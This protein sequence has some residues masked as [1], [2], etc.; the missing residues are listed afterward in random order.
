MRFMKEHEGHEKMHAEMLLVMLITMV[1][2]QVT[3]TRFPPLGIAHVSSWPSFYGADT[4]TPRT[5][6]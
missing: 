5:S 1:L 6:L 4:F 3:A 2:A